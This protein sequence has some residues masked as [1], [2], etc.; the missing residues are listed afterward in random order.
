M[1]ATQFTPVVNILQIQT[2]KTLTTRNSS[3]HTN[4]QYKQTPG[5]GQ[6]YT[7][8]STTNSTQQ[9]TKRIGNNSPLDTITKTLS[10]QHML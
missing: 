5:L 10:Q 2:E 3:Q 8:P 9:Q 7:L 1:L 4:S 6:N